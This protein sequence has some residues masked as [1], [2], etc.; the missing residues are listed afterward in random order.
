MAMHI[1]LMCK[2]LFGMIST[3]PR[4]GVESAWGIW[5]REV[6]NVRQNVEVFSVTKKVLS[7]E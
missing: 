6:E 3:N 2:Y 4:R 7:M 5:E 1:E